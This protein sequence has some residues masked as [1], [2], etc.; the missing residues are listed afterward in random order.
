VIRR[1]SYIPFVLF[2]APF[3]LAQA[4]LVSA[5]PSKTTLVEIYNP[6]GVREDGVFIDKL[7]KKTMTE[8]GLSRPPLAGEFPE[9]AVER[10]SIKRD[11][12]DDVNEIFYQRGWTDG[13]PI[14]PPTRARVR[15]ML[16]GADL[17]PSYVVAALEPM[18]GRATIEKIAVNAVMAGCRPEYMPVLVAAVE[19]A[20]D[21]ELDLRSFSVTTNPDTTMLVVSGPVARRLQ[22]NS[23]TNALGRG[24][25][26]NTTISR[27]FHLIVQNVGGSWPGVTD[28]SCL[29]QPGE[30][31]MML[32]E[33]AEANPW[34]PIHMDLGFPK[35][36][37]VVT[38]IAA[39]GTH[40]IMGIGQNAK[41][42]LKLV[43]DHLAGLERARRT[44]M[45]LVIAQDTAAMLAREGMDREGIRKFIFE[46]ARIP[47]SKYKEK[48]ID[49][50]RAAGAPAWVLNTKDPNAMVPVPVIDNLLI[51]VSGGPG[52]K[53]MLIPVWANSKAVG[54]E[55]RLTAGW[56]K[57]M[58]EGPSGR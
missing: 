21:R 25:R 19:A 55:I 42:Y 6:A 7:L 40:N 57:L 56:E 12:F 36:A 20:T 41:G 18:G 17:S 37:N 43:S 53:S 4:W 49:T 48:F 34:L 31:S 58:N 32:A 1:C 28:M 45:V 15:D 22:I 44:T 2:I 54:R 10:I 29:G 38:V 23:G 27:A 39:E 50:G 5:A 11:L 30:I 46:N 9:T 33:N 47:F 8:V 14:I 35:S 3:I 51:L 16:R 13:L 24:W 26:A 52:E